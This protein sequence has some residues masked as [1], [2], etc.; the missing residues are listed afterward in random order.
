M[1]VVLQRVVGAAHGSSTTPRCRGWRPAQFLPADRDLPQRR[2]GARRAGAWEIGG[3]RVPGPA[4]LSGPP[5][6][7]AADGQPPDAFRNAQ[8]R[9]WALDLARSDFVP[10][11]DY[12]ANLIERDI[13]DAAGA[14]AP[15][16]C[17][18]PICGRTTSWSMGSAGRDPAP[19]LLSPAARPRP[20]AGPLLTWILRLARERWRSLWKWSSRSTC[21][22]LWRAHRP[23]RPADPSDGG[24]APV[25]GVGPDLDRTEGALVYS[26][27]ALGPARASALHDL[28]VVLPG[29]DRATTAE[30]ASILDAWNRDLRRD[31]SPYVLI[32]PGRWAAAIRGWGSGGVVPDLGGA[33]DRGGR[34]R[35]PGGGAVRGSTSSII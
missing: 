8:R 17:S 18:P 26:P 27:A 28:I 1:A 25:N 34:L 5:A 4:V 35:G 19:H 7:R 3:G 2:R 6:G 12:E 16:S 21:R 32:G 13:A 10:G 29:L 14:P 24:P 9:F 31:D 11:L 33:C 22:A 30:A 15:R 20:S 23:P